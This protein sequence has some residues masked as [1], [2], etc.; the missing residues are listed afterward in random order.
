MVLRDDSTDFDDLLIGFYWNFE[1]S[2]ESFTCHRRDIG[3]LEQKPV[4]NSSF[5][6]T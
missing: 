2:L 1:K 5:S 3:L 6:L 4:K